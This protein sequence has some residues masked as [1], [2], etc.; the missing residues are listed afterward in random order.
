MEGGGGNFSG[1]KC[2][3]IKADKSG[4]EWLTQPL[5]FNSLKWVIVVVA[6]AVAHDVVAAVV[7]AV[8]KKC[9]AAITKILKGRLMLLQSYN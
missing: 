6:A 8:V 5:A 1:E 2:K 9:P 7:K 3:R 4:E